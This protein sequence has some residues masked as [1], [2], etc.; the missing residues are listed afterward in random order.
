MVREEHW[1]DRNKHESYTSELFLHQFGYIREKQYRLKIRY[2]SN[3]L[4]CVMND[5][6][7]TKHPSVFNLQS[8]ALPS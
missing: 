6:K 8:L 7:C 4:L 2:V 1:F 3:Y 5:S